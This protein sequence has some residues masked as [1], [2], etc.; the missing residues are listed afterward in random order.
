MLLLTTFAWPSLQHSCNLVI[1]L[2]PEYIG[3]AV[4]LEPEFQVG[5][6]MQPQLFEMQMRSVRRQ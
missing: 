4:K 6:L 2:N 5:Q 1:F 3:I